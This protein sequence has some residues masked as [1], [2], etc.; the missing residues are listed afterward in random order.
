MITL[1]KVLSFLN[2]NEVATVE[3]FLLQYS[4]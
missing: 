2:V 3:F 1:K 4:L